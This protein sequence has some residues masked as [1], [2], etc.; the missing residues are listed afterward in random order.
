MEPILEIKGLRKEFKD[1]SLKGIDLTLPKGYIMGFIG[2]NGAGKSTT[3]KLI[4]NLLKKDSGEIKIFGKDHIKD[5]QEVKNRIGFVF[6]ENCYYEELTV[7]E[8][9]RVLSAIYKTWDEKAFQKY[10]KIFELPPKKKIKALSK[11]MKMKFSLA[12]ALSHHADLLIMDEPTSGLDPLVRSE[13][14]EILSDIIQDENKAVFF[15]THITSDL[16]KM[17]D[18]V[19][20]INNGQIVLSMSKDDILSNYGLAKGGKNLLDRDTR[21]AFVGIKENQFGFEGLVKDKSHAKKIFGDTILLEKP[22]LEDI[23]LYHTRREQNV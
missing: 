16:E 18:Y 21:N 20:M 2:P 3:I 1:F 19:T 10:L 14:L 12:I 17:A 11:G 6:D 13:L 8:M 7:S 4:L 23:M 15:S 9:K 22:T 5:E